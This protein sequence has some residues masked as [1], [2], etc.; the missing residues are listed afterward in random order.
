MGVQTSV[1]LVLMVISLLP[2]R[3]LAKSQAPDRNTWISVHVGIVA[4]GIAAVSWVPA[5][6]AY[7]VGTIFALFVFTPNVLAWLA[8]RH[9]AAGYAQ[10]AAFYG[11]LF[12]I[13]HPSKQVRFHSSFL[14]ARAFES[15]E[16]KVAAY[17]AW[18][19]LGWLRSVDNR[20]GLEWLEIRALGE[21]GHIDEMITTDASAESGL[22]AGNLPFCRLY[23]L[24]FSGRADA[25]RS[26]LSRQLRFVRPRNKVYWIFVTGQAAGTPDRDARR[27]FA[28]YV[29]AADDETFR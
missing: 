27:V 24:A 5:W 3:S 9:A 19:V 11:R 16:R 26:L 25:V 18:G 14:A 23:V 12:S 15:T 13:F 28:S 8:H 4:V 21:L 17:R 10:A 29:A 2:L 6:S 7:M 22:S 1:A 20:A